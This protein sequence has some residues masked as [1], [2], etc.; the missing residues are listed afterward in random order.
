MPKSTKHAVP[1][2]YKLPRVMF[3]SSLFATL[4]LG[5]ADAAEI[6]IRAMLEQQIHAVLIEEHSAEPVALPVR[7]SEWR[8]TGFA[9][10]VHVHAEIDHLC[11]ERIPSAIGRAEQRIL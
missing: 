6:R 11:Q 5:L 9:N 4:I 7:S 10:G 2:P 3:R 1:M 8:D